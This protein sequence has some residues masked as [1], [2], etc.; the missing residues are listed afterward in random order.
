MQEITFIRNMHGVCCT[1]DS[2]KRGEGRMFVTQPPLIGVVSLTC[3]HQARIDGYYSHKYIAYG[4]SISRLL[5]CAKLKGCVK[6]AV[7]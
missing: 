2:Q 1:V 3:I 4:Y 6:A 7:E 5:F